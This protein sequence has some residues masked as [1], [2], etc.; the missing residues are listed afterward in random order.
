MEDEFKP[1]VQPQ[2][3]VKPNIKEVVKKEVIKLLDT[4][5]IYP[6]SDS[7]WVSPVQVVPKKGGMTVV[8]NEKDELIPQRTITGWRVCIDYRKLNNAT[9][10][11]HFPLSFIDQM[12]ERLAGH[13]Y[14]CFLDGFSGYFQIPIALEDQE[15]T[16]FTCPYGTFTYKRMPF[17]LCNAPATFQCCMTA[18]FHELIEDSMEVF[19]DDFSIFGSSFDHCLKTLEKM[20]KRCEETN[21][22]LNWEKCHFMV[23]EGIVLGHKV[24]GSGIE[25]DK[26]KI[27]AISK[28]PYPTNVK[29]V[30]SFLGHAGFYRRFIK[31]FSQIAR[32]MTQLLV[33]DAPFNFSEE[34]IQAFDTLKREL[35][36]APVM[37]KPDWSLPFEIM[38][39]ASDYAVGAVL[40]QR[41]NKH[42]K[43]MHYASKTMNETQENYTTTEKVLLV[44]LFAFDKFCQYLVLSKTIIHDKKGTK[45]L[46]VDH[47]SRLE[48]P[49]LGK[50]T[51]AEIRDL[52]PEERLM[53]ISDKNNKPCFVTLKS[54]G[55]IPK[56][57]I[58]KQ[59]LYVLYCSLVVTTATRH[60]TA[61]DRKYWCFTDAKKCLKRYGRKEHF[62]LPIQVSTARSR[63]VNAASYMSLAFDSTVWFLDVLNVLKGLKRLVFFD[64]LEE[65]VTEKV[66]YH[67]FDDEVEFHR[68]YFWDEPFLFKQCADQI[69]RRCVTEDEAAQILQQCHSGPP[70]GHHGIATTIRKVFE[71]GFYWPH[72]FRDARKLVQNCDACQR[73][74]NIS[75][76]DETPQKYI[77]VCKIFDVWGIDFMGPFPSSNEN[78]YILVAIDYVSKWVE[79]QAFPTS[80]ARNVVNFLRRLFTQFGIPKALISDRGTHFCNY[81]M[82]KAMK[83]KDW[84]Y[85]LVD[86][87]WA[88][89]TSFK[90]PLGTTPFRIIYGKARHLPVELEHKAY[91]AIKNCNMDLTKAGENRLF[92]GK[93]K[94]RWY[95]PFTVRKDMKNGAIEIYDE[96]GSEFI[97]NKQRVKPYQKNLLDTNKDDDVTLDDE[98]EVT[99]LDELHVTWAHLEKKQTRLRTNTKTLEDLCSQSLETASQAIHDAVTTHQVTASQHSMTMAKKAANNHDLLSLI[100]HS[101]AST[102]H[103]YANS[104]YSPQ[105]YYVTYPP[106]VIDYDDEYQG[107]LQ[108]N[109]Q[110]DKLTT[111]MI[112][113]ARAISQ[114]FS[115]PTNNRN[116]SDETNKI[117]QRVR[118]TDST[119][120]K[121]NVQCYNCNEKGHYACD[122]QKPK[123]HNAKYFRE[124]MLL[125]M[126]DEARIHL[127]NKENDFMLDN[128]YG[129]EL[130]DGLT[131]S[132][133][134]MARLQPAV[135]TTD[136][137]PSYDDKAVSQV[138][139]TSKEHEQVS[140]VTRKTIFQT[141]DDDQ[142]DS[143]IIFND[144]YVVNNG[145]TSN[146]DSIAHEENHEIQML[147]YNVQHEAENQKRLAKKAFRERENQYLDDI[148]DLEEKLSSH[149]R[150]V[151]KM[152]GLGY[153]NPERVKKAIA[154][155]P[156]MCDGDMLHNE[157]LIINSTNSEETLEDAEK[158]RNIMKNKMIQVNYDKIN[159]LFETFVPQQEISA[160]Q[161]YFSIPSTSN[162]SSQSKDVPSESPDLKMPNESRLLKMMDK[163]GDALTGFYTKINKTLLKDAERRWLSDSQN[164]LTEFYKTEVIPTSRSLY[165]NLK[166]IKEELIAEVQEMLN[167][168]ESIEQKVNEKNLQQKFFYQKEVDRLLEVSL[169]SEIRD[170]VLLSA[171]QQ[172]HD[173]LKDELKKSSNDFKEIQAN[174]LNRIKI[175]END[176][177]RS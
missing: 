88:F 168:F 65:L 51:K 23:K 16:T 116:A 83:R 97:V 163:L 130:L 152:A 140:H 27:K 114:K 68:H 156:K 71:V 8:K 6:I 102:S 79:A 171:A 63:K 45:N 46:T 159:T 53:A 77:Q 54:V 25:V 42:F 55:W 134:L 3:R 75:L 144:P 19:M 84:S 30:Q 24:S 38:C 91:W 117:V 37:I 47:L 122:C 12:L 154:A 112:L 57:G 96:E 150:I 32:P 107:E 56:K 126:K 43:P 22:V 5:L 41:I 93:L 137:V 120:S 157:K 64:L 148:V 99:H 17:E 85:K 100:A 135:E 90:T 69:I 174:L 160:E 78:K 155:Q 121:A 105:S 118:R 138:H 61:G 28:L 92:P 162:H 87:L 49:D 73:A 59:W 101:H 141:M 132:V 95:G 110:E 66:I 80:D 172:K 177:Q 169:T 13:E 11:D 82:D 128:A 21:L 176:F 175:L 167:I 158:S 26:A 9:Q 67:L 29:V 34:C 125:A 14:Y 109:S 173:L 44:V 48:N 4:G 149:D 86:A 18:I 166:D 52:F 170:F 7:P 127:S 108:K 111:A 139:D 15:K 35:T 39:D 20:L 50:L 145:G 72:I 70:G 103:L 143:C 119:P 113:L 123:V 115:S 133:M 60:N 1:S 124:Q 153:Q 33:K 104:S 165:K 151:Y 36:Q 136:T 142:I 74:G 40:G 106:S 76:R 94:S 129:E 147:A 58:L 98:G 146:H 81:Q 31:D 10:K 161:T 89:R 131:A 62:I 164:E 2:R